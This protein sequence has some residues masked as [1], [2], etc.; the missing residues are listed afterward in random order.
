MSC[1]ISIFLCVTFSAKGQDTRDSTLPETVLRWE[2][3]AFSA[4][5][6]VVANDALVSKAS[7][8]MDAGMYGEALQTLERVKMYFLDQDKAA[9]VL[10]L[11][12]VCSCRTGDYGQALGFLEESGRAESDPA[13]YSLLLARCRRFKDSENQALK[14]AV[15]DAG[16]ERVRQLFAKTPKLK[17]EG[18]AATLSFFPPAGQIYTG[19]PAEG[20]LSLVLNSGA[21]GFTVLELID[22]GWVTGLLGGGLLLNETFMK[23]NIERNVARVAEANDAALGKFTDSLERLLDSIGRQ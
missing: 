14:L 12:A 21:A 11:K 15:S 23:G 7:C 18:T 22:G 4:E 10:Y 9:E 6:P 13:L 17:K 19:R 20:I 3:I 16:R 2:R 8:Y 5:D 1:I